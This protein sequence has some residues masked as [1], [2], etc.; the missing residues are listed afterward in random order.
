MKRLLFLPCLILAVAGFA[1]S[2]GHAFNGSYEGA[3]LDRVAFP[4]GGIGAGMFCLEGTGAISHFS[5]RNTPDLFNEPPFFAA[6]AVKGA[7]DETRVLEGPVPNWKKYGGPDAAFGQPGATWGLTRFRGALFT[8]RF[9]FATVQLRDNTLPL[10]A[11]LV[12][13]SPFIPGDADNSSLPIG[14]F[15]YEFTNRSNQSRDYVFSFNAILDGG[16]K[17]VDSI[18]KGF[19]LTQPGT[20]DKP[21]QEAHFAVTTDE[22]VV[23]ADYSAFR[24]GW[25]DPLTMAWNYATQAAVR[26]VSPVKDP[27]GASLMIPFTLAPGATK[28]IRLLFSWYS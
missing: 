23:S 11:S 8:P 7:P 5:I 20:E 3:N 4:I 28:K 27:R 13:W 15:E 6:I 24:G 22:P 1:Q 10:T 18:E 19:V 26:S 16:F 9:P 25:Y 17:Q 2:A 12:G 21:Y 14:A